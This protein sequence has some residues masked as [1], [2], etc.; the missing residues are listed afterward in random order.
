MVHLVISVKLNANL[1]N[2]KGGKNDLH[3]YEIRTAG[4]NQGYLSVLVANSVF[5]ICCEYDWHITGCLVG[6]AISYKPQIWIYYPE[7]P[8]GCSVIMKNAFIF[9]N[10]R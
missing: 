1:G 5:F 3:I 4:R 10:A 8:Q 7:E 2:V 6:F 9:R